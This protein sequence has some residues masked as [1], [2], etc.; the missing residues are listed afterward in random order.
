MAR[1]R[2][3]ARELSEPKYA[4]IEYERRWLVDNAARPALDDRE[5]MRIEDR[6]L[7]GTRCRLRRMSTPDGWISCKLTKKYGA[8][9][10]A[11][12]PIVTAYLDEREYALFRALA[13]RD[14]AKRR[15][16]LDITGQGWSLD[17]FE[18]PLQ[19]LELLEAEADGMAA[20]DA[21]V[22]PAWTVREIT[23]D[24]RFQCGALAL[25]NIIP[26]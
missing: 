9:D 23:A 2:D 26:E 14:I 19:G 12:R 5:W 24:A 7:D 20:L 6:Y 16:R 13:G 1:E 22:P 3:L 4:S 17:I 10:P 21:L 18:G 11:A 8:D 15:Y 25:G